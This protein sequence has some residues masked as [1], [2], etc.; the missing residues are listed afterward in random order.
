MHN[1]DFII[2]VSHTSWDGGYQKAV[3][4]LMT[5]LASRHQV[6]FVDY[7]YTV[8]DLVLGVLGRADIPVGAVLRLKN[9]LVKK[10]LA[11]GGEL[12]VWVP[13]MA[14]V[15]NWMPDAWHDYFMKWNTA[16][17]LKSLRKAV[18][19]V[20]AD[21]K[22]PLIINSF[23]PVWGLSMLGQLNERGTI[24][25]CYDEITAE[26]WIARHGGR[27]ER[28]YLPK[29][30]AVV[31][32]SE[33]LQAVKG[34]LQPNAFCVKNGANYALFNQARQL[35]LTADREQKIVGYLGTADNRLDLNLIEYCLKNLPDTLF[36]FIGR[37]TDPAVTNRLAPYANVEFVKPVPPDELPP[38]L[39]RLRAGII[40]FECNEHTYTIY[41]LKINE[42][43]AA[44]IPVISTRFSILTDF[45]GL[46]ELT[47]DPAQFV[48]GIRAAST[49]VSP[50]RIEQFTRTAET[51]SWVRRALEFEEVIQQVLQSKP[52][53]REWQAALH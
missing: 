6:L 28:D 47:N 15:V 25:Y 49:A 3:V 45:D 35:A 52:E 53:E 9:P 36:Q 40:P 48:A 12:H 39:A 34:Q 29:V 7:Q 26:K 42:Y 22:R 5:E 19:Q 23:N 24:Y 10:T 16:W 17:L 14:L 2:C 11:H 33:T 21:A 1:Q 44:G 4:Q 38:L 30:D 18:S 43:L 37:V 32:T 41:P 50:D 8:K 20:D 27:C 51:N 13:P 31:T 46:I